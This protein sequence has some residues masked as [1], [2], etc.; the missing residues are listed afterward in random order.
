MFVVFFL[1]WLIFN[2][3]VTLELVL[4]GLAAAGLAYFFAY[5]IVGYT[6]RTDLRM[7]QNIPWLMRYI[8]NLLIEI[9]KSAV[10][11]SRVALT[12]GLR[13]DPVFVEFHSGFESEFSNVLLADS[14]TLTPG[15]IT[16]Y[17]EGDFFVIHCLRKEYAEGIEDSSF[18]RLLR[19]MK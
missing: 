17:Q 4:F 11:V 13:P 12:P 19:Q 2:G 15:T 3:R 7:L 9:V 1:L 8:G 14:I 16:V 5:R 10:E 6:I 18:I